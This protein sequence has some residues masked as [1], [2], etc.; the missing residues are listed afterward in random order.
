[1]MNERLETW[2]II[3]YPLI[4]IG[5]S[6]WLYWPPVFQW[7]RLWQFHVLVWVVLG[8]L[9]VY[10]WRGRFPLLSRA[11]LLGLSM[12]LMAAL[13]MPG[14]PRILYWFAIG[15]FLYLGLLEWISNRFD[16]WW[17]NRKRR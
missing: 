7:S 16:R 15:L 9:E 13:L 17:A 8:V 2:E 3:G 6:L 4:I 14:N 10:H 11:V 12:T 5:L 1:M